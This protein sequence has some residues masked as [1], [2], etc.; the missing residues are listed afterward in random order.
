MSIGILLINFEEYKSSFINICSNILWFYLFLTCGCIRGQS[1]PDAAF[2]KL[3]IEIDRVYFS[4]SSSSSSRSLSRFLFN[5]SKDENIIFSA[6]FDWKFKQTSYHASSSY[7]HKNFVSIQNTVEIM[8]SVDSVT[9]FLQE[10]MISTSWTTSPSSK[11]SKGTANK[12][13]TTPTLTYLFWIKRA[14]NK[15]SS[16]SLWFKFS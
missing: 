9:I 8:I 3:I 2:R 13:L 1:S 16:L 7:L 4:R 5:I 15:W 12:Q 14:L 10:V 6:Y 11:P